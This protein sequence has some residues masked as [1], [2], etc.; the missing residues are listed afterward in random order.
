MADKDDG[1]RATTVEQL[2]KLKA[3][4]DPKNGTTTA[5]NAS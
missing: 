5:G 2:G 4:F 1:I 3:A